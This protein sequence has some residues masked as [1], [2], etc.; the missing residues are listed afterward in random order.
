M[1]SNQEKE[2][3]LLKMNLTRSD[4]QVLTGYNYKTI[5][6]IFEDI[7]EAILLKLRKEDPNFMFYDNKYIPTYHALPFLK[8]FGIDKET[9]INNARL[10]REM[11]NA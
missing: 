8:K 1:T 2:Q 9:I 4:I 10:E 6:K 3:V 7:K 11:V 5:R